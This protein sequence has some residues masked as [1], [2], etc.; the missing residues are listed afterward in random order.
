MTKLNRT[1][2]L[3]W[4][5]ALLAPLAAHAESIESESVEL[6]GHFNFSHTSADID[7]GGDFNVTF[8]D[9]KAGLGYFLNSNWEVL[10]QL[11]IDQREYDEQ[12]LD[13]FGLL[14]SAYYHFAVTG[15]IIPFAGVGLG[16]VSNG[17]D[18]P[19]ETSVIV[20]ELAA[21]IRWPFAQ[22]ASFN[23]SAGYRH[24]TNAW[25]VEDASGHDFFFGAG[26][27]LFLQGGPRR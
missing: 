4:S 11:L 23:F 22:V 27:S 18:G 16:F 10:G 6:I 20:P 12:S 15:T 25:G 14:A 19:D 24:R 9:L 7:G 21:G 1:S 8:V 2:L 17:G 5:L 26:F 3:V 13:Y